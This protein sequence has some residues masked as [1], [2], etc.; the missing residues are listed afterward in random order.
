[1]QVMATLDTIK[2]R[3]HFKANKEAQALYVEKKEATQQ[4]KADLSLLEAGGGLGK[5]KKSLK[6]AK[7]AKGVTKAPDNKMQATFQA[8]LEKAKSATENTKGMM[9][10]VAKKMLAF[11]NNLLSV[12]AKYTWNKIVEEQME[13]DLYVDLQGI[14]QKGPRGISHQSFDDCVLFHL[15][16]MFP[17]NGAEQEKYYITNVLKKP[18]CVNVCQFV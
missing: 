7:E 5:T 8:D 3:G 11:Y 18:Q 16:T 9:T 2:K 4:A 13:G 10:T 15:L 14:S 1:M 17:I 12:K 6:K